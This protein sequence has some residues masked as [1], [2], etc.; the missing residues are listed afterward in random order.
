MAGGDAGLPGEVPFNVLP[1]FD[2]RV[3]FMGCT[4]REALGC[5]GEGV[6]HTVVG[7]PVSGRGRTL[8]LQ[9][10]WVVGVVVFGSQPDAG[11]L[12]QAIQSGRRLPSRDGG[13]KEAGLR[14]P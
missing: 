1:V 4:S 7:R 14:L 5:L 12:R 6:E 13:T 3:S 9:D 8:W 10:G 11:R 2:R